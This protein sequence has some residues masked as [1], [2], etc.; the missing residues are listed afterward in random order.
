VVLKTAKQER[1]INPDTRLHSDEMREKD[2]KE[3][4]CKK[5]KRGHHWK[6]RRGHVWGTGASINDVRL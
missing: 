1:S 4:A 6:R 3:G 2:G 5:F